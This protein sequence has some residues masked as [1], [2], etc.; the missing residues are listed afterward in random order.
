[1]SA[2]RSEEICKI[3]TSCEARIYLK[4]SEEIA[5]LE[6][7]AERSEECSRN[8]ELKGITDSQRHIGGMVS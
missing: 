5:F 6:M 1:M 3:Q 4:L 2:E 7:K 8:E